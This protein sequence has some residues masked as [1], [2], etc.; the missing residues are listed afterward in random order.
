MMAVLHCALPFSLFAYALLTLTGG[1]TAINNA[2]SSLFV[3]VIA[4]AWTGE[5]L[6]AVRIVGLMIVRGL[7]ILLGTGLS[8]GLL[9]LGGAAP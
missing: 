6:P 1:F 8:T 2:S 9:R 7:V 4:W 5:R 3:G